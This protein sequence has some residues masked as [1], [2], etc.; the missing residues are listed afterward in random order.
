[1]WIMKIDMTFAILFQLPEQF[2][3]LAKTLAIL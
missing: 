1:M 3:L 2:I